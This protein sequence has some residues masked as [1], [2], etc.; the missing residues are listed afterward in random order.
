MKKICIILTALVLVAACAVGLTSGVAYG[1]TGNTLVK[2]DNLNFLQTPSLSMQAYIGMQ[3][4]IYSA[5]AGEYEKV[6]VKA[7]QETPAGKVETILEGEDYMGVF[8]VF[9]Q[10]IQS[11]SMTE[12][13]TMTLCGEKNGTIYEGE[14]VSASV[15]S[16][17]MAMLP[18]YQEKGNI[19]M[20]TALVDMLNY[21][22]N[23]QKAF[24]HNM[25]NLPNAD[26]GE[27][28]AYGSDSYTS[29][30]MFQKFGVVG[31]SYAS[32]SIFTEDE[33]GNPVPIG[34]FYDLSWGQVMARR[35]GTTCTN[36]SEGS[37]STR[38]WLT[39]KKGL[40][41]LLSTE[42]QDVYYLMLGINDRGAYNYVLTGSIDDIK[43]N[44][45]E[46][47][48]SFYGN[49]GKII[50]KIKE[51]APNAKLIIS[52]MARND[53]SYAP[54]NVAIQEIAE[55]FDIPCIKQH[56][57]EFFTSDF[58]KDNIVGNHPTAPLYAGMAIAL[59]KMFEEAIIENM[60][61][62]NDFVG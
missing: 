11:W 15:Q 8:L 32:G 41:L 28:V 40:S 52:T 4:M 13:V 46:N 61:Y 50:C 9:E 6:Y 5:T 58:Y 17:T 12:Q 42:P 38:T 14:T 59:Q 20:C 44:C 33:E 31:D 23:V 24:N 37:L 48:D 26:L 29:L 51:H 47:P 56:E 35:L 25:E 34:T 30:S 43:E 3:V 54:F 53:G 57:N 1:D 19:Q 2:A 7:A 16:L 55:Y 60:D 22:A 39:S 18:S 10:Q 27:F 49:Y 62:F 45:E 36:F 21:G